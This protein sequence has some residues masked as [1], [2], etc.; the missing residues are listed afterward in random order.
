MAI[1][2]AEGGENLHVAFGFERDQHA[3]LAE[4]VGDLS[5]DV[6]RD[7]TLGHVELGH[8]AQGHVLADRGDEAGERL[9]DRGRTTGEVSSLEAFERTVGVEGE[10]GGFTGEG[11]EA[12]V[13]RNEVG[14]GIHFDDGGVMA[15]RFDG[16]E[17]LGGNAAGLLGGLGQALLAQPVDGGF[18]V[19]IRLVQRALA[20]HHARAGLFAEL[21]HQCGGDVGHGESSLRVC[22]K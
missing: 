4:A 15:R 13:A 18:D 5:V 8:A 7:H 14:L 9:L 11:L 1:W 6:G 16:D 10:L 2:T 20:V 3:D 22:L 19:A 17:A 12:V 21:F